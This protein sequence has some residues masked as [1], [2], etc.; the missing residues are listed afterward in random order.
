MQALFSL[1]GIVE[2]LASSG[3]A[4]S[5]HRIEWTLRLVIYRLNKFNSMLATILI[6]IIV[7]IG[8]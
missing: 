8:K 7:T 1:H 6:T 5:N 3:M 2:I 4:I